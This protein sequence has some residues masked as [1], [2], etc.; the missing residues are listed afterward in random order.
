[1]SP[2]MES[3]WNQDLNKESSELI[4]DAMK[5]SAKK[6]LQKSQ[7]EVSDTARHGPRRPGSR[8]WVPL[9]KGKQKP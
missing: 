3:K 8:A 5:A 9:I 4:L 6:V 2:E 1:M 7:E